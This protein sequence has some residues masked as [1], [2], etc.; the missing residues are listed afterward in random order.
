M[1]RFTE[2][3]KLIHKHTPEH[4]PVGGPNRTFIDLICAEAENKLDL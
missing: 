1:V 3:I 2:H 4:Q